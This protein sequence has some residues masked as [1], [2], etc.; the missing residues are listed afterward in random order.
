MSLC[1][2]VDTIKQLRT[3]WQYIKCSDVNGNNIQVVSYL[4]ITRNIQSVFRYLSINTR[5]SISCR[6]FLAGIRSLSNVTRAVLLMLSVL[7]KYI[8]LTYITMKICLADN[9]QSGKYNNNKNTIYW[10]C[11][12]PVDAKSKANIQH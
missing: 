12:L 8:Y 4:I 7:A 6:K 10:R 2:V 5:N 11:R 3:I 9:Y 1:C